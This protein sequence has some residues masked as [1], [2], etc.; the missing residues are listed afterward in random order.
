MYKEFFDNFSTNHEF[1]WVYWLVWNEIQY[2][3]Y[4]ALFWKSLFLHAIQNIFAAWIYKVHLNM[5]KNFRKLN[6]QKIDPIRYGGLKVRTFMFIAG[7]KAIYKMTQK[8]KIWHWLTY[9]MS[10]LTNSMI[11]SL[12]F[13]NII[14]PFIS[15]N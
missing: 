1:Y 6:L 12:Y 11:D 4:S 8:S 13:M 14:P 5:W 2:K 10:T 3:F 7:S 9:S 15:L